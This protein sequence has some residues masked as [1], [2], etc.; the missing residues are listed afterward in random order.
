MAK[1]NPPGK[2]AAVNWVAHHSIGSWEAKP[3]RPWA[4]SPAPGYLNR[5]WGN[6]QLSASWDFWQT[7]L[8]AKRHSSE[9]VMAHCRSIVYIRRQTFQEREPLSDGSAMYTSRRLFVLC[10]DAAGIVWMVYWPN[11]AGGFNWAVES[12]NKTLERH[13]LQHHYW[14]K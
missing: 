4:N 3:I 5:C 9:Y 7:G 11:E 6:Y 10:A 14:K 8:Q 2:A 13:F 12:K 1:N